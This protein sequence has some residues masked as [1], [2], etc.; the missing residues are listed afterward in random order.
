MGFPS[1]ASGG[2]PTC[3]CRKREMRVQSLCQEDPWRSKWP[4]APV[5]LPE[6]IAWTEE[7]GGL[8]SM[9]LQRV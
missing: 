1:A 3:Q 6:K 5:F 7:S 2:D 8:Q 9:Q 4:P